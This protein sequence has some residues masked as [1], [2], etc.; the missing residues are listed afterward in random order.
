MTHCPRSH[1][2]PT[3]TAGDAAVP[4]TAPTASSISSTL[5]YF[6]DFMTT[7]HHH[8]S[9]VHK[10]LPNMLIWLYRKIT[11]SACFSI[12]QGDPGQSNRAGGDSPTGSGGQQLAA[13]QQL[14][15]ELLWKP[16]SSHATG[17]S[18]AAA[19]SS[20]TSEDQDEFYIQSQMGGQTSADFQ[21]FRPPHP[22]HNNADQDTGHARSSLYFAPDQNHI[23]SESYNPQ[24]RKNYK[25]GKF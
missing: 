8:S 17:S 20:A 2:S 4:S 10:P 9:Q 13:V 5:T 3:S 7:Y 21:N 12:N 22:P 14:P 19:G 24:G 1:T 23:A 11:N 6:D 16:D 15:M 18:A 25:L